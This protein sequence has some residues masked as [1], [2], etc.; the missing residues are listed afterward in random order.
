MRFEER[1]G[2]QSFADH[3]G[4]SRT[5]S[6]D[7]SNAACPTAGVTGRYGGSLVFDGDNDVIT[8]DNESAYD[9]SSMSISVWA[10]IDAFTKPWQAI[11]SKGGAWGLYRYAETNYVT[12]QT[13]GTSNN[14]TYWTTPVADGKWHHYAVTYDGSMEYFYLD[15]AMIRGTTTRGTV[16]SNNNPVLIGGDSAVAGREFKG[17]IDD[18]AI[19]NYAMDHTQL[20]SLMS[21]KYTSA[22][23]LML[24][25]DTFDTSLT[26]ANSNANY[27]AAVTYYAES[28]ELTT[29]VTP[30][31]HWKFENSNSGSN[32]TRIYQET[33]GVGTYGECSGTT[34]PTFGVAGHSN[35][36]IQLDDGDSIDMKFATYGSS[37]RKSVAYGAWVYPIGGGTYKTQRILT[38]RRS[39]TG[40]IASL[41]DAI[42]YDRD[43]HKFSS[44]YT[45][46]KTSVVAPLNQWYHIM[47]VYDRV[48]N[49]Q[50][51]YLNGQLI[52]TGI[53]PV[54]SAY[55]AGIKYLHIGDP[56]TTN[57]L[58]NNQVIG[59]IGKV[60]DMKLYSDRVLTEADIRRDHERPDADD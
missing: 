39:N 4:N 30:H 37:F 38:Y 49:A 20:Q 40:D 36:G 28:D 13:Q 52:A 25:G 46:E 29:N 24:P 47:L 19:F 31:E 58:D 12:F 23:N 50:H 14:D 60:D 45:T 15:G 17:A 21:G 27:P 59:F 6:C 43:T 9:L 10:K 56:I 41:A 35:L 34:C 2:A 18:L 7:L 51:L 16:T 53:V 33:A 26:I 8:L 32:P 11:V 42:Y 44:S 3:S 55:E 54:A 1:A 57:D 5:A 22:D 48:S